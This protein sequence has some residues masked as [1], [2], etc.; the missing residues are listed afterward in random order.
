MDI[1][2]VLG[3]LHTLEQFRSHE[4]WTRPQL[5]AYQANAL[6]NLRSYVYAHSPFYQDFH[7]GLYDAPLSELP[8]LSKANMMAHFDDLVTEPIIHLKELQA[9]V[10][11]AQSDKRF[12]GTYWVNMTSGSTG[13]PGIFLSNRSEWTKIIASFARSY[14]WGGI[15]IDLTKRRKMAVVASKNPWHMSALVGATVQS[16]WSPSLRIAASEPL[17]SIVQQLNDWQP[18]VFV[19]YASMA[20]IL[21][22]EQFASRLHIQPKVVFTSSEV[23]TDE[24]RRHVE[25]AWGKV[26][27]NQYAATETGGLAAECEAHHG[28]HLYEDLVIFEFVDEQYQPVPAGQFAAKLLITS[29]FNRTQPLIRYELSDSVQ[30][31]TEACSSKR[32]FALIEAVQGRTEDI[33]HFPSKSRSQ[34]V[35]HP[36]V[37]HQI[38][39]TIPVEGWQIIQ[40]QESDSLTVLLSGVQNGFVDE[41]LRTKLSRALE[42]Q[43]VAAAIHVQRV[44]SIP[45]SASGKLPLI[46][47]KPAVV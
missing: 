12:L 41:T 33:L 39:D 21:A 10:N 44:D 13:R 42:I 2:I 30:L 25:A 31:S 27:F 45:K 4:R 24:T 46:K 8:V 14:E 26:L 19:A 18:D 9:Y 34:V 20:K 29:L 1:R 6:K 28:M 47:A 23:L 22:D 40:E 3:L 36:N 15:K 5:E 11:A 37:F 16:W 35:V 17:E 43:G 7:R 38:M 32:P